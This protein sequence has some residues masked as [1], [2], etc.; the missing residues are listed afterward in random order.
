M[1]LDSTS[2]DKAINLAIVGCGR[3]GPN[4]I[5]VF[6]QTA[7]AR[8]VAAVEPEPEARRRAQVA[9][10]DLPV[11]SSLREVLDKVSVDAVVVA[12]P[13]STHREIASEALGAGK[14]VLCEKPLC[15]SSTDA[16]EL[17]TMAEERG[18]V[19]MVG[20]VFLFNSGIQELKS[21]VAGGALGAVR[22][23]CA[24]RTNLGPIRS[25]VNAAYDLASHDISIFNWLLGA[26]PIQ[27]SACGAAYLRGRVEDVVTLSLLYPGGVFA[28]IHAS[29][30]SP[31]KLRRVS[32]VGERAM[33]TWEDGVG[34]SLVTVYDKG[35]SVVN[36]RGI[37]QVRTWEGETRTP[38]LLWTE[39]L[40]A[41]AEHFLISLR[42]S[43]AELRCDGRFALGVSLTLEAAR[44]SI[45]AGGMPIT[46]K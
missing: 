35:A 32:V 20:Y 34:D 12:T 24:V 6:S 19:L 3:W 16:L 31:V 46:L 37:A 22:H 45:D 40:K 4:H 7:G 44:A 38:R 43:R 18:R 28:T 8:V 13:A 41:Q 9:F 25:D 5:R 15:E 1:T 27:I 17:V 2:S 26:A 30:L 14:H 29:W 23:I 33:A 42:D 39:P 21:M 10:P 36:E 11:L